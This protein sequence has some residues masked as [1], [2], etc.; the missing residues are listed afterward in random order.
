MRTLTTIASNGSFRQTGEA[1]GGRPLQDVG[2]TAIVDCPGFGTVMI[3]T[4]PFL[5]FSIDP[6]EAIGV[7]VSDYKVIVAKG[8]IAP[9]AGFSAVT[10]QFILVD[11]PGASTAD[12]QNFAFSHRRRPL[13]PFETEVSLNDAVHSSRVTGTRGL[14]A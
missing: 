14:L 4:L 3:T 8:V 1:H 7:D 9:R 5:P 10:D 13:F 6:Y 12:F 2:P 11:T